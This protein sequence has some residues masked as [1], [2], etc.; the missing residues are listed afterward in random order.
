MAISSALDE[1][2]SIPTY[3]THND[4]VGFYERKIAATGFKLILFMSIV[5]E[6]YFSLH[7]STH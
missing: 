1:S 3:E 4:D 6:I 5:L 7:L 2:P